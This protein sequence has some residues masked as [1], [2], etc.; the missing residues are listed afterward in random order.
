M[1]VATERWTHAVVAVVHL[2]GRYA[3]RGT[4]D[5][6]LGF[7]ERFGWFLQLGL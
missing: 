4:Y 3:P 7:Q 2:G 6:G 5:G 1:V